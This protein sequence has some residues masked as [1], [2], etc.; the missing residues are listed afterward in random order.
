MATLDESA[1]VRRLHDRLG[2]GPRPGD[3]TAG[4]TATANAL[5]N[6]TPDTAPPPNLGAPVARP[7]ADATARKQ[8]AQALAQQELTLAGWW[9]DRMAST[10]APLTERLTWFWHGHFATSEQKVRSPQLM[11]RQNETFRQQGIG[12]FTTLARSLIV[13][14]AMLLWLDGQQNTVRAPN[15]NLARESMELFLLGIGHYTE[16]DVRAAARAL[17]GWTVNRITGTAQ[18]VPRRH[19]T[20]TK[21]ILGVS[22]NFDADSFV[23][24]VLSQPASP[25]FVAGRLWFRLVS[26]TPPPS[27]VLDRLVAGY[28]ATRSIHGL[29][30]ALVAE[31]SF[32]DSAQTLVKQPVEWLVGLL[33]A[34]G[35]RPDQLPAKAML[36][37]LR[38]LGQVPFEPPNVGGWPADTAWLTTSAALTRLHLAQAVAAKADVTTITNASTATRA[39]AVRR[40]LG[41][42]AWTAR[43]SAALAKVTDN[44]RALLAIAACAPEFVVSQ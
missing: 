4:F 1:A 43:T 17:T 35:L 2:F 19:D 6:P 27:D 39:E 11:L 36:A 10:T 26:A 28:G 37:G 38:A 32:L 42:D 22:Q 31:P 21:T 9:L 29:L 16:D 3:L 40:L 5:L 14:P 33:R 15:E 44:P 25:R 34:V 8:A 30:T 7:G 24:L 41:V 23:D 20:G 18:L 13:D 12:D